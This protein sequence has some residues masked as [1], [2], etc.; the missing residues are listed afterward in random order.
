LVEYSL[1]DL[2][3]KKQ[4]TQCCSFKEW[5]NLW[6]LRL[7]LDSTLVMTENWGANHNFT[8]WILHLWDKLPSEL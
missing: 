3:A 8:G 2:L 5:N 1:A 6:K 7:R 4:P